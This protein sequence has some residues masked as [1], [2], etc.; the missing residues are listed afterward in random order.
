MNQEAYSNRLAHIYWT[1]FPSWGTYKDLH[2]YLIFFYDGPLY[3][4]ILSRLEH[5][6]E[7]LLWTLNLLSDGFTY[8]LWVLTPYYIAFFLFWLYYLIRIFLFYLFILRARTHITTSF[9]NCSYTWWFTLH[10]SVEEYLLFIF[11]LLS[12]V[13][14]CFNISFLF[15]S[16]SWSG[17]VSSLL[18]SP[19]TSSLW[20]HFSHSTWS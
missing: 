4:S 1:F 8:L 12:M 10:I 9:T 18:K 2:D 19:T 11:T 15:T 17:G 3:K 5:I 6:E 14:W 7:V 16:G 13:D 20:K